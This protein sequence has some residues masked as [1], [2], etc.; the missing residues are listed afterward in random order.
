MCVCARELIWVWQIAKNWI[1][2]HCAANV[3]TT[4]IHT[5][6]RSFWPNLSVCVC[7]VYTAPYFGRPHFYL[8]ET[9]I[10][11]TFIAKRAL[12]A[13]DRRHFCCCCFG[14]FLF[15]TKTFSTTF[16]ISQTICAC[17]FACTR[18]DENRAHFCEMFVPVNVFNE[19]NTIINRESNTERRNGATNP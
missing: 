14:Y 17:L 18:T 8:I 2:I 9:F 11:N 19:S 5:D 7:I 10:M 12:A 13:R 16:H 1:E 4:H 3:H 6:G 15:E